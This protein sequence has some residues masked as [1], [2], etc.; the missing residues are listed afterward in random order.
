MPASSSSLVEV[1]TKANGTVATAMT[2]I[3]NGT[4]RRGPTRSVRRPP[5]A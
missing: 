4:T 5:S 3:P 2:R 1:V